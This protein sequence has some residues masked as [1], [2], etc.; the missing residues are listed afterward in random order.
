MIPAQLRTRL[1]PIGASA[2]V[3]LATLVLPAC[4][5]ISHTPQPSESPTAVPEQKET[6][7]SLTR[8]DK[9]QGGIIVEATW[10]TAPQLANL[11]QAVKAYSLDSYVL[12]HVKLDTHSGDISQYDVAS[13][14]TLQ[15]QRLD[16]LQAQTWLAIDESSHHREG[17]LV[18]QASGNAG[19]PQEG[20]T[21]QLTVRA[22]GGVSERV[23]QWE[24]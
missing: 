5:S 15:W 11:P 10:V 17:V 12:I 20:A 1:F 7:Q 14:S 9:G 2:L 3:V 8:A 22:V 13:L 19:A 18:F 24:F 6:P 4:G 16:S 23:F 21:A